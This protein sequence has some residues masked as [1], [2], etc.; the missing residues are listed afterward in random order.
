MGQQ[1][2]PGLSIIIPIYNSERTMP[3]VVEEAIQV[4]LSTGR[5]F[6]ILLVNDGSSDHSW[7]KIRS[8]AAKNNRV[9]GINLQRNYGQHNALLCGIRMARFDILI[10]LDDDMQHPPREIPKLLKKL[11]ES[12]ADVVYGIPE[13]L[14]HTHIRNFLSKATKRFLGCATGL[15]QIKDQSPFRVFRTE[16]RDSFA[17]FRSPE[18]LLDTL[19]SWGTSRFVSVPVSYEPRK[20]GQSNYTAQR[21]LSMA[22]LL[23][24]SYSTA[25]LRFASWIGIAITVF[26]ILS[27]ASALCIYFSKGSISAWLLLMDVVAIFNGVLMIALGVLGEYVA[28]IYNRSVD[29]PPYVIRELT[30]E[31]VRESGIQRHFAAR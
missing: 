4:A 20:E 22:I 29:Q 31:Q 21:L 27:L 16:L 30:S 24:T 9:H 23:V 13:R 26:G 15:Q 25:P 1:M 7:D 18:I 3:Y 28:R 5:D 6:E 8:I 14:T 17:G 10:T 19:L 11:D 12:N 2:K